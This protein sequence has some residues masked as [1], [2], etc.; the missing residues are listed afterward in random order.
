MLALA[1]GCTAYCA[2]D[3]ESRTAKRVE[4]KKKGKKGETTQRKKE[5]HQKRSL[6]QS[7][8]LSMENV[9]G[10]YKQ[11]RSDPWETR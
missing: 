5:K 8:G 4:Q 7:N 1:E 3:S 2:A 9:A 10:T 6:D 11:L